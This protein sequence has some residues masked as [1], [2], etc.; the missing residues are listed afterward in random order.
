MNTVHQQNVVVRNPYF[1][2][3]NWG[4]IFAGIVVGLATQ[5]VLVLLGF[6]TGL[7][8]ID[9][10]E[11]EGGIGPGAPLV[12]G[13]W[14]GVSMLIAAFVGGYVAARMSGLHRKSDGML[15]G[16]VAW[17][18]TTLLFAI[19]ATSAAGSFLGGVFD[20]GRAA[21]ERSAAESPGNAGS[22]AAQLQSLIGG[23]E[24]ATV[25]AAVSPESIAQLQQRIE[26]GDREGAVTYMVQSMGL[27]RPRAAA[28]VDQAL[29]LSGNAQSASPEAQDRVDRTLDTAA[30]A[31]WMVFG[32]VALS[33]LLGVVGGLVGAKSL[34]RTPRLT[35]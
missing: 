29:I 17:A 5:L 15:H 22:L 30:L 25:P 2:A 26:A 4:A 13:A 10:G 19:L 24:A 32:A 3:I 21:L 9:V 34:R 12:A 8:A 16:F 11:P 33:L 20:T 14:Q 23:D 18:V 7:W 28:I 1:P 6:A 35:V 27:E 31:T